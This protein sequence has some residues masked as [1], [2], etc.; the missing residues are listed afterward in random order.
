[1]SKIKIL[2]VEDE[3]IIAENMKEMLHELEYDVIGVA[4]DKDEAEEILKKE[5][6]DVALVD[7]QLRMGDDGIVLAESVKEKYKLPIIFITSHSDRDTVERAKNVQPEGYIVKPFEKSDLYTSIEIALSNFFRSKSTNPEKVEDNYFF[8]EYLFVK[9]KYQFEKLRIHDIM[10]IKSEGNYLEIHSLS[11]TKYVIRSTFN[12]LFRI[13][14]PK[15]FIQVHKSYAVN[16]D[17]IDSVRPNEIVISKETV[18]IGKTFREN[19]R[20]KLNIV[21]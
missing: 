3:L 21:N 7:I 8:K 6:P 2:I 12:D 18:P 5:I 15:I 19:I 4:C 20:N 14:P 1:M 13:I 10:W 9:K 17:H 16:F 11:N